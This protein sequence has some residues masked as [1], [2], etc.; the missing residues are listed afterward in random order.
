MLEPA[1]LPPPDREIRVALIGYGLAGRLFHAPLIEAVPAMRLTTVVTANEERAAQVRRRHPGARVLSGAEQLF[2]RASEH[3]LV[4]VAAP[5][6]YH[7][8][9]ATA[10]LEA[11]LHTVVDKPMALTAAE[12][13]ALAATA[14]GSGRLLS[15]FHNRRL[16]AEILTLRRL[17]D[18]GALGEVVRVDS[19][20]DRWRPSL[21]GGWREQ[22]D[23][24]AGGGLL[25]DL[26]SHLVDQA[27]HLFGPPRQVYAELA[28][29][30]PGAVVEDDV[31]IAL[32]YP[33]GLDVH[34]SAG[35]LAVAPAP[36]L[37]A[38]GDRGSYVR[39]TLDV[40]EDALR[41]GTPV[42]P[43]WGIEPP[44]LWGRL[45]DETGSRAVESEPGAWPRFYTEV[46]AAIRGEG[47]P[48][49]A[50]DEAV[51]VMELLDAARHSA[52]EGVAV[53]GWS[54]G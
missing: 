34:L 22:E 54:E 48:P 6:R 24:A 7:A 42:H 21:R 45:V 29:R 38:V 19:R 16:D 32:H 5:N 46:A 52:S 30:R 40:Q 20:F 11:G 1:P 49:V 8:P 4:V 17:I 31:F 51:A 10:A 44:A 27:L 53:S 47:P 41:A 43:G 33:G 25:L 23:A 12:A 36:R 3:D 28:C 39:E 14:R 18:E 2:E 37:R 50:A 26:G 35:M 9:L 13:R 15:V